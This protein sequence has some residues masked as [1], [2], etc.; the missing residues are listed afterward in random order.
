MCSLSRVM[1]LFMSISKRA[2]RL[3]EE[4]LQRELFWFN[5]AR[6][7]LGKELGRKR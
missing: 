7:E 4:L 5:L 6:F 1:L 3:S 2:F